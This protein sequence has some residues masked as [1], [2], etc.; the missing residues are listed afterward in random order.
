[1]LNVFNVTVM[2]LVAVYWQ[3]RLNVLDFCLR[4][5]FWTVSNPTQPGTVIGPSSWVEVLCD[6]SIPPHASVMIVRLR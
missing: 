5:V 1:M 2:Y 3:H 6:T 4:I